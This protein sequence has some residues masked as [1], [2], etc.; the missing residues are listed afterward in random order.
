LL[1]ESEIKLSGVTKE[2]QMPRV[3]RAFPLR[4]TRSALES[5]A[6]EL[7]G[8]RSAEATRFYQRYGVSSESWHLQDTPNG[9]WVIAVTELADPAEAAPRYANAGE[10][11]HVWFKSQVLALTGVDPNVTPLGPPT[12]EVFSWSDSKR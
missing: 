1:P 6:A 2:V 9:P 4:S 7:R 12:T 5:F 10:E 3:V 8:R 11:F